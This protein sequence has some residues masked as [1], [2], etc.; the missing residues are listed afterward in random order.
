MDATPAEI[1]CGRLEELVDD[2]L[3]Q[4]E[5]LRTRLEMLETASGPSA[6]TR[7]PV[8]STAPAPAATPAASAANPGAASVVSRR[9]MLRAGGGAAAAGVGLALAGGVLG[10]D[11]AD[12]AQNGNCI[13]GQT[14]DAGGGTT[15]INAAIGNGNPGF[16]AQNTGSGRGIEGYSVDKAG[17]YGESGSFYGVE[18]KSTT[19]AG[20]VGESQ[21]STGVFG[22]ANTTGIG[23]SG[24]SDSGP[25][26]FGVSFSGG[27]AVKGVSFTGPGGVFVTNDGSQLQL[28]T[29]SSHV[30][31]PPIADTTPHVAGEI[32][33]DTSGALWF[34]ATAGTPGK[35]RKVAGPDTAGALHV[36]PTPIRVYD[37]RPGTSPATGPKTPLAANVARTLDLTLNSSTVPHGATAAIVSLLLVNA[38]AGNGNFTIWANGGARPQANNMVWGGNTG[39]FSSPATTALD[40]AGKCQV[41]SSLQTDFVLDVVGYHR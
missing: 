28:G 39:R 25:G 4:N 3:G 37:S 15:R 6:A 5:D 18:G 30:R 34:C 9:G 22:L 24:Q 23:V 14:N 2:L 16:I 26:L 29:V 8:R 31:T 13:L 20:V 38:V 1:R 11:R 35:W 17:V 32:V 40:S 7:G 36:L 19:T 27:P 21:S 41:I 10:H 33:C 12:A